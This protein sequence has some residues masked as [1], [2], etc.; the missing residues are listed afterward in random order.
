MASSWLQIHHRT[1]L[2][3]HQKFLEI[4]FGANLDLFANVSLD[5]IIL[6]E[7][8]ADASRINALYQAFFFCEIYE[9]IMAEL[10]ESGG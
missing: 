9:K 4:A 6:P 7:E 5:G 8:A 1:E 2:L 3:L 10:T